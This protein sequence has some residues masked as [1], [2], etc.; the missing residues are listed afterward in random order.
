MTSRPRLRV[1]CGN[2]TP[3][4]LAALTVV[5]TKFLTPGTGPQ[6]AP[7]RPGWTTPIRS[8]GTVRDL[9]RE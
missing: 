1:T 9:I 6:D 8:S 7:R 3:E 5:L 2:P 4:E